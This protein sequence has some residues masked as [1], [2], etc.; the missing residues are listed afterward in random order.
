MLYKSQWESWT[1]NINIARAQM[2]IQDALNKSCLEISEYMLLSGIIA[3]IAAFV[4]VI[5]I[6][7]IQRRRK[8]K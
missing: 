4:A 7:V 3:G 5:M 6:V 2:L 1:T 8:V